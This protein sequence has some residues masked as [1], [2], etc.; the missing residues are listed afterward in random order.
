MNQPCFLTSVSESSGTQLGWLCIRTFQ[1]TGF[2][3]R[4][5]RPCPVVHVQIEENLVF[6]NQRV[7]QSTFLHVQLKG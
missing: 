6:A 1:C 3:D 4:E 5:P 2:I 7:H